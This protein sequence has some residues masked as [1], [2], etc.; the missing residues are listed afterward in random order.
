[1]ALPRDEFM[2]EID[3]LLRDILV[4]Y[5]H[6]PT[7]PPRERNVTLGQM[8]CLH[9]ISRL[10]RPTMSD[11]AKA[12]R[13]HPSTVT[14]LVDGLVAHGLVER[15]ADPHDRRI[16]RVA[17]TAEGAKNRKQHGKEMRRRVTGLLADLSDDELGRIH[18]SLWTLREAARRRAEAADAQSGRGARHDA[19]G[20]S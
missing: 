3:D 9:T 20:A 14:V 19:E 8:E 6:P 18:D 11:V 7:P 15:Q 2:G 1:M 5:L 17:E 4:N 13:L 16:V 10:G 12:L